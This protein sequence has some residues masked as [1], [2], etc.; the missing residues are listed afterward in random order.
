LKMRNEPTQ[1]EEAVERE[2]ER[3]RDRVPH[4]TP[5]FRRRAWLEFQRALDPLAPPKPLRGR[6]QH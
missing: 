5:Y 1:S 4:P 6:R 2:V 3:A